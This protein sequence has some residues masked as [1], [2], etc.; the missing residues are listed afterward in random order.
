MYKLL[1]TEIIARGK[2]AEDKAWRE[3]QAKLFKQRGIEPFKVYGVLGREAGRIFYEGLEFETWQEVE[4]FSARYAADEE[5]QKLERER[6]ENRIVVEG[7]QE[8]FILTDY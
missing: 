6:A 5:I 8:F 7:T 3:R 4:E 2:E 1:G